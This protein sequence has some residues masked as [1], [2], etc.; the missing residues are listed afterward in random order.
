MVECCDYLFMF[1]ENSAVPKTDKGTDTLLILDNSGDMGR[2]GL[3]R[4]QSIAHSFIDG[5]PPPLI[6]FPCL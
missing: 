6:G 3:Q 4:L 5:M 2:L 1:A